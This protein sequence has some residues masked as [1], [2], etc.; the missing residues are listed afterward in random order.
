MLVVVG[1]T[2][3]SLM[4]GVGTGINPLV[5]EGRGCI[6]EKTEGVNV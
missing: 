6:R 2:N 1:C 3:I 4:S 5:K